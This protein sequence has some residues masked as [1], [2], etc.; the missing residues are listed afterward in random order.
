LPFG[1]SRDLVL[2][3]SHHAA[4][5]SHAAAGISLGNMGYTKCCACESISS[6][7][8]VTIHR[9]NTQEKHDKW[10]QAC[11]EAGIC[12]ELEDVLFLC[13]LHFKDECFIE[14]GKRR[15]LAAN[16]VPTLFAQ[17]IPEVTELQKTPEVGNLQ[18]TS[19]VS[20]SNASPCVEVKFL[21][22]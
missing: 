19:E 2:Q 22:L 1:V 17:S 6:T 7:S 16:A 5:I 8:N 4:A 13:S 14:K 9:A 12:V 18:I 10:S 20:L 21:S 11:D 15:V 3:E